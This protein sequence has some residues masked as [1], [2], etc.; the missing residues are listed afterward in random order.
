MGCLSFISLM[1][2]NCEQ[3]EVL[4]EM[5]HQA[6]ET[7]LGVILL[8]AEV[9]SRSLFIPAKEISDFDEASVRYQ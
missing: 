3:M 7:G 9:L 5:V 1:K 2:Q 4:A 8:E 6:S